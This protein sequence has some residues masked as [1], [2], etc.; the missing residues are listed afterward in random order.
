MRLKDCTLSSAI[1]ET[2]AG[3]V[4]IVRVYLRHPDWLYG[5]WLEVLKHPDG[6][7]SV[8]LQKNEN[9]TDLRDCYAIFNYVDSL[10][11]DCIIRELTK[12]TDRETE[13]DKHE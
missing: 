6:M 13:E 8:Y 3:V 7:L 4:G 12:G 10:T 1:P 11:A 5:R 9:S 2:Y